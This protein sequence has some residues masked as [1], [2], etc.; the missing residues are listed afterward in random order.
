M[1]PTTKDQAVRPENP[2]S[3]ARGG[4][5]GKGRVGWKAARVWIA[6]GFSAFFFFHSF[7]HLIFG[8]AAAASTGSARGE[9]LT[10]NLCSP[11]PMIGWARKAPQLVGWRMDLGKGVS[12]KTRRGVGRLP[13]G[14]DQPLL[15][16]PSPH[17]LGDREND[18]CQFVFITSRGL[19]FLAGMPGKEGNA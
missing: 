9:G 17:C 11:P 14:I 12:G 6:Y 3:T 1:W 15:A 19:L 2:V 4:A 13:S 7:S 10:Q 8:F 5:G 16:P 18:K